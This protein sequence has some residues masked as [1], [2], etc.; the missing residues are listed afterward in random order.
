MTAS[1]TLMLSHLSFGEFTSF[2]DPRHAAAS[3]GLFN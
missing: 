1:G 3:A 2:K